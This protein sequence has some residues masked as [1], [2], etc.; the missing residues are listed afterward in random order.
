MINLENLIA[1][2]Y[3]E[4]VCTEINHVQPMLKNQGHQS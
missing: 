2:I 1:K 3:R 4:K